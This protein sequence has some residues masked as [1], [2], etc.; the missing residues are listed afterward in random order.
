MTAFTTR[1]GGGYSPPGN[2]LMGDDVETLRSSVAREL[3]KVSEALRGFPAVSVNAIPT[4]WVPGSDLTLA[5][6]VPPVVGLR[7]KW[8][9][10]VYGAGV[11]ADGSTSLRVLIPGLY[12]LTLVYAVDAPGG[13]K[14]QWKVSTGVLGS[15]GGLSSGLFT[16]AGTILNRLGVDP[17]AVDAVVWVPV[18][19]LFLASPCAV[20][21]SVNRN[22]GVAPDTGVCD[23][24]VVG[25][26]LERIASHG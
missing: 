13:G 20:V 6:A 5:G 24:Y 23:A 26:S 9:V 21:V 4:L 15:E 14:V 17:P 3:S 22:G 25:V 10:A 19:D 2:A 7:G 11:N 16:T 18:A 12:R 1:T 8:P